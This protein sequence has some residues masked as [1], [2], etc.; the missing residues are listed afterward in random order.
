MS[1][2]VLYNHRPVIA[3]AQFGGKKRCNPIYALRF[4]HKKGHKLKC[5]CPIETKFYL[6]V[7]YLQLNSIIILCSEFSTSPPRKNLLAVF[8]SSVVFSSMA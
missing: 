8:A 3:D 7:S 1:V 5:K 2:F 6:E 4:Q